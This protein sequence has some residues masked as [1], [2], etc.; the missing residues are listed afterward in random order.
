MTQLLVDERDQDFILYEQLGL[1]DYARSPLYEEFD[2]ETYEMILKEAAKLAEEVM[3]PANT[4]GD[5]QGCRLEDGQARAPEAFHQVWRLFHEG[6]WNLLTIPQEHGGQGLPTIIGLAVNEW[7]EAANLAFTMYPGLTRGAARLIMNYGTPEQK[8]KY[9]HKMF[10]GQYGG[11]M[12]LTE[13][14]AGSD[15]GALKTKAIRRP[16]GLYSITGSKIFISSG[17]HDLTENIV[18]A[19][20]AR[21]EGDPAGTKGISIF[22]VPKIRV[23]D[24]GTLGEPNDVKTGALEHKLGINGS[25]TAQLIFGE[26]GE[27]VGELL[28]E[29]QKGMR[30][31]FQMMNEARLG[32]GLQGA[33]LAS[34]A[35]R[36]A[37][38]YAK[39]RLQGS[40]IRELKN[41]EAPQAPI[42][43]HPDVRRMLMN[44][45]A[46][47]EGMRALLMYTAY[48][49]DRARMEE[50][51]EQQKLWEGRASLLTPLCKSYCTDQGFRVCE[52][53]MQ[54]YGGY[55]YT[56][57]Y[58]VEQFLRDQ[59][60]TS[61]YEGTNGIQAMDLLARKI[62]MNGGIFIN[63]QFDEMEQLV[64]DHRANQDLAPYLELLQQAADAL[65][66]ATNRLMA[67]FGGD[68]RLPMFNSSPFLELLGDV[69]V[70]WLL[71]WQ[72]AL[73][74]PKLEALIKEHG[75]EVV[76]QNRE[77]AFYQ[78]K[79]ATAKH[80]AGTVLRLAPAKAQVIMSGEMVGLDLPENCF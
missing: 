17:D 25:A 73:A 37:L 8:A 30:V 16:D 70:G 29:E 63:P 40:D 27:C 19:V 58:P 13:P 79:L 33:S 76:N 9:M 5:R 20:L 56:Q 14:G 39:E 64:R 36:H 55:G 74:A 49:I 12:V 41:H 54:V 46:S 35:Y 26:E 53:A 43:R 69:T 42:I 66:E 1:E 78:G 59:K 6:G 71:L 72:A 32:V 68:L 11:T 61:I 62:T 67:M 51:E 80:F 3:F 60:I 50:T 24:D 38:D 10:N 65:R 34:A 44:M 45:K 15:V 7:F 2:R 28:G 77:A 47:T 4:D 52:T 48:A 75:P 31:M 57:D 18:H 23:N 21:I 22:L